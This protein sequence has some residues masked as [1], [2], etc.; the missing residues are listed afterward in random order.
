MSI[1]Q[2]NEDRVHGA[3]PER[4]DRPGDPESRYGA[5]F[6]EMADP[7]RYEALRV[8]TWEQRHPCPVA[9]CRLSA[10]EHHRLAFGMISELRALRRRVE[11]LE[12]GR[13]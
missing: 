7:E 1:A 10:E 13:E 6:E 5:A 11:D 9:D 2:P 4:P 8:L 3:V 12:N